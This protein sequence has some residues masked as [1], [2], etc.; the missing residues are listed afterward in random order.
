MSR[1]WWQDRRD[2]EVFSEAMTVEIQHMEA[3]FPVGVEVEKKLPSSI[4]D[5]DVYR[6]YTVDCKLDNFRGTGSGGEYLDRLGWKIEYRMDD[7]AKVRMWV[8][9]P[10]SYRKNNTSIVDVVFPDWDGHGNVV[11]N[12]FHTRGWTTLNGRMHM[13]TCLFEYRW[14]AGG[15]STK[16]MQRSDVA[17]DHAAQALLWWRSKTFAE[18]HDVAMPDYG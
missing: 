13:V 6:L 16:Q 5:K 3:L 18:L 2:R 1:E 9:Y 17:A 4:W 12:K 10:P 14:W 8:V 11:P 7:A 15:L